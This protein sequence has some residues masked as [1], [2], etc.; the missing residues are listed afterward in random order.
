MVK[1][2]FISVCYGIPR[3]KMSFDT[4]LLN[5][6]CKTSVF[7]RVLKLEAHEDTSQYKA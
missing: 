5:K 1:V 6:K 2:C 3:F 4:L 7:R